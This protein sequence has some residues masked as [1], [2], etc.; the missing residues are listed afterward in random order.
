MG[1]ATTSRAGG[2]PAPDRTVGHRLP[3]QRLELPAPGPVGP[4]PT[5]VAIT[6][7]EEVGRQLTVYYGVAPRS[8]C[9][10]DVQRPHV[11]ELPTSVLV[12]LER[13]NQGR[14]D[15]QCHGQFLRSSVSIRLAGPMAGRVLR[16]M[17][18]RGALVP[19][20]RSSSAPRP[21]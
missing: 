9:S 19:L 6:G 2:G 10:K 4:P 17:G 11:A 7:Y 16:D 18:R 21:S 12:G 13:V 14:P 15:E 20:A 3:P 8:D 1:A 5:A